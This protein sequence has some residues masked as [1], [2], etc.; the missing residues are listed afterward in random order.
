M[1]EYS[2][3][4][5]IACVIIAT[6]KRSDASDV[7]DVTFRILCYSMVLWFAGIYGRGCILKL[8]LVRAIMTV[9]RNI[10]EGV[11]FY[12]YDGV[13]CLCCGMALRASSTNKRDKEKIKQS[14]H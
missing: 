3:L 2:R 5:S 10:V 14:E 11:K 13:F 1:S 9:V 7:E 4:F 8:F 12:S 6:K